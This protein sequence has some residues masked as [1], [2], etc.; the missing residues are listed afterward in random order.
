[1]PDFTL[2]GVVES[3][4]CGTNGFL[5]WK[6]FR[7]SRWRC[8]LPSLPLLPQL[9]SLAMAVGDVKLTLYPSVY[10]PNS[11]FSHQFPPL[12]AGGL[13]R[14]FSL[15]FFFFQCFADF[16]FSPFCPDAPG[17]HF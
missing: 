2:R 7:R 16:S 5:N 6:R 3:A 15:P 10:F 12:M 13:P 4:K 1:M 11:R 17:W 8:S 14:F 9:G